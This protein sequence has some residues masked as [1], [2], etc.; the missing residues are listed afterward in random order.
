MRKKT[1]VILLTVL[2]FLS[3]ALLG[4][5]S[6]FRVDGVTLKTQLVSDEAKTQ[7]SELQLRLEEAYEK[8]SIFFVDDEKA[9]EIVKEYP[10]FHVASFKKA[11]PNRLVIEVVEGVEVYAVEKTPG[12]EYYI[13]G[14]DGRVLGIRNA[15]VNALNGEPNVLVKGLTSTGAIGALPTGDDCFTS[16]L[17]V[18]QKMSDELGGIRCNVLSVEV[19]SRSPERIYRFT[20][21]EGVTLYIGNPSSMMEEKVKTAVNEYMGLSNAQKLTGRIVISETEGKVFATYSEND[22]FFN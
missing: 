7:A 20:M 14:A 10:Y 9:Q 21:R 18:C 16:L 2:V 13:L 11:H 8:E 4:V 1:Y 15:P 22:E 17:S 3:G 6:V 12:A 19:F 5:S